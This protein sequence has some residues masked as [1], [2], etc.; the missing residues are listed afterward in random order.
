MVVVQVM[1]KNRMNAG[2]MCVCMHENFAR[3][4]DVEVGGENREY[5]RKRESG[6]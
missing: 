5:E 2:A 3:W 4:R 1:E 6:W